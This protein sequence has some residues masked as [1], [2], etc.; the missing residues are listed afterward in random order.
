MSESVNDNLQE[1]YQQVIIDHGTKPRNKGTLEAPD[2]QA[3]GYNPLCGDQI[4]LMLH[5]KDEV[6]KEVRFAGEGCAISTA[7]AS[8]LT[9]FLIGKTL[10][11]AGTAISEFTS[12]LTNSAEHNYSDL[13]KLTILAGVQKYPARVKCATLAWHTLK[14]ALENATQP[15]TTE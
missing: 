7:S 3:L 10:T 5:V 1:L 14:A 2:Y 9:Q 4:S 12:M 11:Q 15:A 6:I 13:G 8:L